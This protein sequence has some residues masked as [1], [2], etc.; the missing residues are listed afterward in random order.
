[1]FRHRRST[2][3]DLIRPIHNEYG[4]TLGWLLSSFTILT[5]QPPIPH[6]PNNPLPIIDTDLPIS[7]ATRLLYQYGTRGTGGDHSAATHHPRPE[8]RRSLPTENLVC[9]STLRVNARIGAHLPNIR[10]AF[11]FFSK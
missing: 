6:F 7:L 1:M 11:G 3:S 5:S 4:F 10:E 8:T 2:P 9:Q